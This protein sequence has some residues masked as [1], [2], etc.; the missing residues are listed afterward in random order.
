MANVHTQTLGRRASARK[1]VLV[2]PF[3]IPK[4]LDAVDQYVFAPDQAY[5]V[6]SVKEVHAVASDQGGVHDVTVTKCESTEAPGAGEDMHFTIFNLKSAI[7]T[8]VTSVQEPQLYATQIFAGQRMALKFGTSGGAATVFGGCVI[9]IVLIPLLL[10]ALGGVLGG[11]TGN[12]RYWL[13]EV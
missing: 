10:T 5:Q 3:R 11:D 1:G 2:L 12:K 8:V 4:L 13:S 9:T 7:N 6:V